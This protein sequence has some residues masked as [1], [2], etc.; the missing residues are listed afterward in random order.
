MDTPFTMDELMFALYNLKNNKAPGMDGV[1]SE[2]YKIA[3]NNTHIAE[4][5]LNMFNQLFAMG[6]YYFE[7][8]TSIMHT[9]FKNKGDINFQYCSCHFPRAR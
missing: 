8:N 9:I 4:M 6:E 3:C 1:P 7:W 5:W 2:V